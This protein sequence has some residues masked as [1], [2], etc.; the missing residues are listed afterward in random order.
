MK[1]ND[2]AKNKLDE[3]KMSRVANSFSQ[4]QAVLKQM[5]V[6]QK[7]LITIN[8]NGQYKFTLETGD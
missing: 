5:K 4:I 1:F 8:K 2:V 6:E 3:V 7:M